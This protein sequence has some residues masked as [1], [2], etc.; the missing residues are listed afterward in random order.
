MRHSEF[1]WGHDIM[2]GSM[3]AI[4]VTIANGIFTFEYCGAKAK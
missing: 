1:V 2:Q 3:V 4:G